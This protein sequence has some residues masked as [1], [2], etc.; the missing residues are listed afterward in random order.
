MRDES[1]LLR[2]FFAD[3]ANRRSLKELPG[4]QVDRVLH[5]FRDAV[6]SMEG[7][8]PVVRDIDAMPTHQ[9]VDQLSLRQHQ[10][11]ELLAELLGTAWL[12]TG[13]CTPLGVGTVHPIALTMVAHRAGGRITW[14]LTSAERDDPTAAA[15]LAVTTDRGISFGVCRIAEC[16]RIFARSHRGRP[17][18]YCSAACKGQGV[19]SAK[20]RSMYVTA[21]RARRREEDLRR[22]CDLLRQCRP[23]D[24]Y[25]HLR[26][27]FPGRGAKSILYVMRQAEKRLEAAKKRRRKAKPSKRQPKSR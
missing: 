7:A 9:L 12:S 6:V 20:K 26:R 22:V 17:Q 15:L 14:Q 19:P 1:E 3:L 5:Q 23:E 27:T 24:R 13:V 11:K 4:A 25:T 2:V 10:F 21:Y 16:R 18:K 8:A